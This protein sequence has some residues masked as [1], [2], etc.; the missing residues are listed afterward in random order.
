[1][2]SSRSC[3]EL[4]LLT[5]AA[6]CAPAHPATAQSSPAAQTTGGLPP[7]GFGSLKQD[8]VGVNL[9]T[10]NLRIR[11]IPLDE[12]VIRLLAPDAYRSLHEMRESRATEIRAAARSAGRDSVKT[13]MVTF[14]GM[15]PQTRF[16]PDDLLITSQNS[17]YRP[18]GHV[19]ITPRF[20]ENLVDARE[21]A[22]AIYLYEPGVIL[23]R[24]MTVAYGVAVSES[25]AATLTLLNAE[26]TRVLSRASTQT[27]P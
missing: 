3:L 14:F 11:V 21:Q 20:N 24:P 1:M 26:R 18:I 12:E 13:F 8:Q 16:N 22:A 23:M 6:A 9:S 19:A 10:T 4:L 5:A 7:A 17:T 27:Q 15:Q 2:R 25:W